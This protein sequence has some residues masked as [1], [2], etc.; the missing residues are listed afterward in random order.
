MAAKNKLLTVLSEAEQYAI[1]GLPDFD[2]DQRLEYLALS[3]TEL[4]LA[5]SRP[6]LHAQVYCILQIGYF[7]AKHSFFR[8]DWNEVE[9]DCAFVLSRY[10]IGDVFEP[11]SITN[12]EHYTQRGRIAALFGYRPWT[13]DFLPELAHQVESIVRRDV[14]PG[15]IAAELLLWLNEHKIIRPGYTTLQELIS[16]TLSAE[17]RRLADLL[18][19]ILDDEAKAKLDQLLIRDDTLSQL[20]ALKQDAKNF[21]W[22]QM[23]REREKRTLL[24]PLH[25]IAKALLPKLDVSQQNLLYYASLANFYTV[26]DLRHLKSVQTYLYLLCYAWQRYRQFTD[27]LVDAM[28][29]HMKQLEDESSAVAKQSLNAVQGQHRQETQR[30]GRLLLLY[31]DDTVA[32]ATAFG[33]VRQRAYKI[34]P[35]DALQDTGQRMS[36]KPASKLALHWQAV[37]GLAE[38]IRR[39]LRPLYAALDFSSVTPDSPWL[40]ALV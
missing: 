29:F 4:E 12:H 27:N 37:D 40:A 38:R 22:R 31:V 6:G 19:E 20:A 13:S 3:E 2:N 16:E 36:V 26:H 11:K 15:F 14:S 23:A 7:K 10:F 33:D 18:A 35:K 9:D 5:T 30:V 32:D 25:R 39:H 21:G 24:E 17:R 8:F 28:A 1:Y 34:M